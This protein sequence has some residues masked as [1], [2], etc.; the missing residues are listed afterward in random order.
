MS[1]QADLKQLMTEAQDLGIQYYGDD[2]DELGMFIA[3]ARAEAGKSH[4]VACY[5]LSYDPTDRRCRICQLRNPC[6]DLDRRPRIEVLDVSLQ[7]VPCAVCGTGMLEVECEDPDTHQ[8]RD[9]ACTRKGCPN[10]LSIQC[11]WETVGQ[12]TVRE[13]VLGE[14]EVES[15][16]EAEASGADSPDAGDTEPSPEVPSGDATDSGT[17]DSAAVQ[18]K[19]KPK[20][21]KSKPKPKLRVVKGGKPAESKTKATKKKVVVKKS[22]KPAPVKEVV[23]KKAP[24]KK[25][26]ATKK[27]TKKV[28]KKSGIARGVGG[29]A[30]R[31]KLLGGLTYGSLSALVNDV[32]GARNWSPRKFFN[33]DPSDVKAGDRLEREFKGVTYIVE[34]KKNG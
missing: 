28:V 29:G 33:V 24:V 3:M 8:L 27:V 13:V 10:T 21:P 17:S 34:V 19:S 22:A 25:A 9:Y 15:A 20:P 32:T 12:S 31:Y 18:P 14:H 11:G 30:F 23:K 2:P 7:P 1:E 4:P 6:A 26:P 5:G 16:D